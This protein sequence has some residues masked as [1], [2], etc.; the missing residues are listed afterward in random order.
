MAFK[1]PS[2]GGASPPY[3][4]PLTPQGTTAES[5]PFKKIWKKN[6]SCLP[7][8]PSFPPP[9][10][11]S[12][13]FPFKIIKSKCEKSLHDRQRQ[14]VTAIEVIS[15]IC[16]ELK[17][18]NQ[19]ASVGEDR[20]FQRFFKYLSQGYF[21]TPSS[22]PFL[23]TRRRQPFWMETNLIFVNKK[24]I[25]QETRIGWWWWCVNKMRERSNIY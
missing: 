21:Q 12:T 23:G 3:T 11:F 10:R 1:G 25:C 6:G 17:T 24:R 2:V 18:K 8:S 20:K 19:S 5:V 15:F 4:G 16:R 14:P 22:P 7:S 13:L 9:M